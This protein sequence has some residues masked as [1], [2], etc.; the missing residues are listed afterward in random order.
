MTFGRIVIQKSMRIKLSSL[1]SFLSSKQSFTKFIRRIMVAAKNQTTPGPGFLSHSNL[2]TTLIFSCM[3]LT[4]FADPSY[5]WNPK[6]GVMPFKFARSSLNDHDEHLD[7]ATAKCLRG[8]GAVLLSM[9]FCHFFIAVFRPSLTRA[10]IRF[11]IALAF[12]LALLFLYSIMFPNP[13]VLVQ[14]VFVVFFIVAKGLVLWLWLTLKQ[15]K[16]LPEEVEMTDGKNKGIVVEALS[17]AY[18]LPAAVLLTFFPLTVSPG[19][20]MPYYVHLPDG[21]VGFNDLQLFASRFEGVSLLAVCFAIWDAARVPD[22]FNILTSLGG[23]L[24]LFVFIEAIL[25]P[26]GYANKTIFRYQL[27]A[28]IMYVTLLWSVITGPELLKGQ[29]TVADVAK[30]KDPGKKVA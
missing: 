6:D 11:K 5:F 25:D 22:N 3:G 18:T 14:S 4:L 20:G 29:T 30:D 1:L 13:Q 2:V 7:A 17:L 27:M 9:A 8:A 12:G 10:L 26:S 23:C 15:S 16:S 19:G 24:Y 21:N 28:H